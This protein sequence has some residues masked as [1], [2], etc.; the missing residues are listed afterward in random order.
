MSDFQEIFTKCLENKKNNNEEAFNKSLELLYVNNEVREMIKDFQ[1]T[2]GLTEEEIKEEIKE[3]LKE[4]KKVLKITTFRNYIRNNRMPTPNDKEEQKAKQE[5]IRKKCCDSFIKKMCA[6]KNANSKYSQ[7]RIKEGIEIINKIFSIIDEEKI[8][9]KNFFSSLR[10]KANLGEEKKSQSIRSLIQELQKFNP[11]DIR[12]LFDKLFTFSEYSKLIEYIM[13][14]PKLNA[15]DLILD[16]NKVRDYLSILLNDNPKTKDEIVKKCH[17]KEV[18]SY[19]KEVFRISSLFGIKKGK[20]IESKKELEKYKPNEFSKIY[21]IHNAPN[22]VANFM[23]LDI[24]QRKKNFKLKDIMDELAPQIKN[25]VEIIKELNKRSKKGKQSEPI[26][27][28]RKYTLLPRIKEMEEYGF[29]TVD[30]NNKFGYN[31][32]AKF[33]NEEQKS[34][35]KYVVPFFCG[36]YPFASIGHF[37]ANRLDI[38]DK[39]SIEPCNVSNILDDCIF[40][41]LLDAINNNKSISLAFNDNSY[42]ENFKPNKIFIDK[43]NLLKIADYNNEYYLYKIREINYTGKLKNPIFSEIYSFYYKIFE[44]SVKLYKEE[45]KK[46]SDKEKHKYEINSNFIGYIPEKY[47]KTYN[48]MIDE[49]ENFGFKKIFNGLLPN[50]AKLENVT[51]P[52]T[53][54][55][56]RWLKTIM[57]DS[58]FDLFVS[59]EEKQD[60]EKLVCEVEPFDLSSFKIYDSK[61]KKCKNLINKDV[62]KAVREI[63]KNEFKKKLN[64][65]HS[66]IY[67][68]INNNFEFK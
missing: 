56:L 38:D 25:E 8:D 36:L 12:L 20:F 51:V 54:L 44:D 1:I 64:K 18:S 4:Q 45:K 34:A 32:K 10:E 61:G 48:K 5:E 68:L 2:Y 50:L 15:P 63:D 31:L 46:N 33:L 6:S 42:I 67:S 22:I 11:K 55:E 3:E 62:I 58:R 53:T 19:E 23:I 40:Y 65:I 39:F 27:T 26:T 35:L 16:F 37:L 7:R 43:K 60:L 17:W 14:P 24:L 57:S 29:I 13:T 52:L 66:A 49:Q 9:K 21:D 47:K 28:F 59:E 30:K 41:D